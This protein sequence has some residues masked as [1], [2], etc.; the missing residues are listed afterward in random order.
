MLE[1]DQTIGGYRTR[2]TES[3]AGA[4]VLLIHGSSIA[5]DAR[6]TWFR[7]VPELEKRARVIT[8]DQPG[9][10]RSDVPGYLDR[11]ARAA[12]ARALVEALD[13][14]DVT[15]V[16]HS[17][18]GYVAS[19][20]AIDCPD[21][22]RGLVIVTSGG[23]APSLGGQRDAAWIAASERAYDYRTRAVDEDTFV[24]TEGHLRHG[25]DPA[26]E[27]VLRENFRVAQASGN[28]EAFLS[29][30]RAMSGY[31]GYTAIQEAT[32]LPFLPSLALPSLLIWGS[33]DETVPVA[34]G[35]AL[36]ALIPGADF[37]ALDA[38]HWVMHEQP[39]EFASLLIDFLERNSPR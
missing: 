9:F 37:H 8:Y 17:E 7:L 31:T 34:R 28:R 33:R 3:G 23:T 15:V 36:Q 18:G 1:W 19:R 39:T 21:R 11:R 35:Q 20:L 12:H 24:R 27:A 30:A 4:P 16:G 26:F 5:V 32:L 13:L 22:I 2:L 38:G 25:T 14:H 10:G 29:R 6:L